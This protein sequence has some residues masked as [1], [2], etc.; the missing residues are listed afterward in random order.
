MIEWNIR[1]R[2]ET[3]QAT[4]HPFAEKEEFYTLLFEAPE[5]YER[6]DL[7]AEAFAARDASRMPLSFWK[8]EFVPAPPPDAEP[9]DKNDAEAE[10]RRLI[11]EG[12]PAQAKVCYLLA[13][14]LERKRIL[15]AREKIPTGEGRLIV[16]EHTG[17]QET[18][19]VPEVPFKLAD[20]DALREEVSS[21]AS[22]IFA[23][24]SKIPEAPADQAAAS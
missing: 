16:Y 24:V 20:I 3:C 2:S 5:G 21:G 10:L 23:L 15:K 19:M 11:G 14:L 4:G 7:C 1:A 17:T 18:F 9:V 8:S 6:V 22:R 12:D 13:L